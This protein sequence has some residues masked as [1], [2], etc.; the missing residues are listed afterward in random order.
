MQKAGV[1]PTG[2]VMPNRIAVDETVIQVNDERRWLYA[3]V[4]A[5]TS[6]FLYV[7]LFPTGT[8]QLTVLVL[9]NCNGA[10]RSP[11]R[12]FWSVMPTISEPRCRG[13]DSDSGCVA[14][15][16]GMLSNMS[17]ENETANTFVF[18]YVQLRATDDGRTVAASLRRPAE[19][20]LS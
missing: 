15:E 2:D 12:R 7:R 5:E 14:T 13:S 19:P 9:R 16:I 18:K 10:C 1:Q 6:K 3:A 11:E 20:C 8:T 17:S 4:D